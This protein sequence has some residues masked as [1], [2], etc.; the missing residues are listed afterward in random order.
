M[1]GDLY[2]AL[3][4]V[5]NSDLGSP[6]IPNGPSGKFLAVESGHLGSEVQHQQ[7]EMQYLNNLKRHVPQQL[8]GTQG[9]RG[10]ITDHFQTQT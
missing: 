3:R 4:L 10:G 7:K 6:Q 2:G 1:F 5:L 8:Q 9:S